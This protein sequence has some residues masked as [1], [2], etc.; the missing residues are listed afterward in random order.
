MPFFTE[1]AIELDI[2][3]REVLNQFNLDGILNFIL[4]VGNLLRKD[5]ILTDEN[6]PE[7]VWLKYNSTIEELEIHKSSWIPAN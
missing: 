5:V 7:R 2:D 1:D 3:P 6:C 4:E